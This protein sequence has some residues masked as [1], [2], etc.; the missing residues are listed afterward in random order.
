VA[1]TTEARQPAAFLGVRVAAG[2]AWRRRLALALCCVG[3][4]A[5]AHAADTVELEALTSPELRDR[6]AAGDTTVLL[7]VG[8]TE[9]SGAHLVLGKHNV[10]VKVLAEKIAR[11]LGHAVV[12][13][14]LAYVPEGTVE[15]ASSHMRFSGTISVPESAF[16]AVIEGAARSLCHHG[17]RDV[18]VIGDHGGYQRSLERVAA[19]LERERPRSPQRA[20]RTH[21]LSEYYHAS[22]GAFVDALKA[23]GFGADEIGIH[24]G[25]ADTS[26]ALATDA[27][28]VRADRLGRA[29]KPGERDGVTGD[30]RRASA[31]LGQVGVDLIVDTSVA[32]IRQRISQPR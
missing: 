16:E 14:V 27:S 32:A 3:V 15:P 25:L 5:G 8:G 9:Q 13:P 29:P 11:K 12:A 4:V 19:R 24:A 30:P 26:L 6:I 23:R 7:P 17:F 28:L 31:D 1:T 20:C 10:R 22:D 21:A 18:V 2:R